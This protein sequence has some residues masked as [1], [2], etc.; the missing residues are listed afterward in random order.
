MAKKILLG[1]TTTP[2]SD[3]RGKVEECKKFDIKEIALFPTSINFENRQE[4]YK[5][6][7][8]SPVKN[9]PHVHLRTD[10]DM[11]ELDYLTEKF[12]TQVFNIHPRKDIHPFTKNYGR[13]VPNIYVENADMA[14]EMEELEKC[15]GICID[16]SHWQDVILRKDQE[17][18]SRMQ[19][20]VKKFKI[21]CSHI[22]AVGSILKKVQDTKY[23]EIIYET[24][25]K[26]I[27]SD[28]KEL[29]YMKNFLEYIPEF[30]SIELENSFEEQLKVK[31][32]LEDL[33]LLNTK[34][35]SNVL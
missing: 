10:M 34:S 16:F 24:Y 33:I 30:V 4:L 11:D 23:P 32:Y 3:W 5:L 6:L 31:K 18:V 28:L 20:A 35:K 14:P 2:D 25:G 29:N 22:S 17:H 19:E 13:H 21:G 15:G 8:N 12:H 9:I 26:H 7:E 1:L 27:L